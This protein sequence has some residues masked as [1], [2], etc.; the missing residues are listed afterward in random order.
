MWITENAAD[1]F[2][3]NEVRILGDNVESSLHWLVIRTS[4]RFRGVST[5]LTDCDLM[6]SLSF[7]S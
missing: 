6:L 4:L 2:V 5:G 3:T 1:F 7:D